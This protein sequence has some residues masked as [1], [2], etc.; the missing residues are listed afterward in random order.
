MSS[1]LRPLRVPAFPQLATANLVNELGNWLGE[2]A[3]AIL[4][5]DQTGSPIATAALFVAVHFVPAIAG[6]PLVAR[7]EHSRRAPSWPASTRPRRRCSAPWPLLASEFLLAAVLAFAA[8]DGSLASAARALTRAAAA[9]ALKPVGLLRRATRF[10]ISASRPAR[11]S[12]P[13]SRAW[14]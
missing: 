11:R 1:T 2:I 14:W 4:V 13:L 10:S 7:L 12:A 5:F 6:P 8:I 3:L 9:G